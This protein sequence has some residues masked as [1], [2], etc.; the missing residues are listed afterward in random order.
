VTVQVLTSAINFLNFYSWGA[1]T[2]EEMS[3]ELPTLAAAQ[4]AT[5]AA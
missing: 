3:I 2:V 1:I 4:V 5:V